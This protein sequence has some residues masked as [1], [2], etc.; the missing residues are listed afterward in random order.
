MIERNWR[1]ILYLAS[2][3]PRQRSAY[4]ALQALGILESLSEYDPV[5]VSTVA[6]D[7]DIPSSDLDIICQVDDLRV[8]ERRLKEM[9]GNLRGFQVRRSLC[10][11]EAIV[12]S[13]F[14]SGW[15]IEVFGQAVPV[16]RQNAFRHLQQTSRV[17]A[18]GGDLWKRAI[19]SHKER[20]MK[21]EPA[22][23]FA[24][25]LTGDPYLAVLSLERL[26]EEEL[27]TLMT[28]GPRVMGEI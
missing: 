25:R 28:R 15:E 4:V 9:F 3:T 27:G 7:I 22:V 11:P 21:T 8:F 16:E 1:D 19:R 17:I 18:Q 20:G 6:I 23:A 13:F 5:L 10:D 26:R 2:G 14:Y 12:S 24:L